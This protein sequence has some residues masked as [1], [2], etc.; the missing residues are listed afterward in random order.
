MVATFN[1]SDFLMF[2]SKLRWTT[3]HICVRHY[4]SITRLHSSP[5]TPDAHTLSLQTAQHT[6]GMLEGH[7]SPGVLPALTAAQDLGFSF[8][9]PLRLCRT[10]RCV[11]LF[12][13]ELYRE[14]SKS[15][16]CPC[17]LGSAG[18]KNKQR[19]SEVKPCAFKS[20]LS[21]FWV[22]NPLPCSSPYGVSASLS[23]K[24]AQ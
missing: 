21:T 3:G 23:D 12:R 13:W 16:L 18:Q 19:R 10:I 22:G 11:L 7:P 9:P 14:A 5:P 17:H 2:K 15:S 24:W 8:I 1:T 20:W 4:N 6:K